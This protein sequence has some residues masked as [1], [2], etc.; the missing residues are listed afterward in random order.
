[1]HNLCNAIS[2]I[3]FSSHPT[4]QWTVLQHKG[5]SKKTHKLSNDIQVLCPLNGVAY[6]TDI[7]PLENLRYML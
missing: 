6:K 2:N 5:V 7:L 3:Y 1:M 4:N